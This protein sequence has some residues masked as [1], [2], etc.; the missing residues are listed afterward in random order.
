MNCGLLQVTVHVLDINDNEPYF[1]PEEYP[2]GISE[3][4]S[5][6]STVVPVLAFDDDIGINAELT[7]Q[8]ASGDTDGEGHKDM[9]AGNVS[10][11]FCGDP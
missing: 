11:D 1:D 6:G 3:S 10:C 9:C 8:I 5:V 4:T 7:F 2:I